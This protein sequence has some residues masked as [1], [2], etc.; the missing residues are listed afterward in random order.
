MPD[1]PC[2]FGPFKDFKR[3]QKNFPLTYPVS[4]LPYGSSERIFNGGRSGNAYRPMKFISR[5]ENNGRKS[6]LF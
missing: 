2:F 4:Y 5:C 6:S 3:L 1:L